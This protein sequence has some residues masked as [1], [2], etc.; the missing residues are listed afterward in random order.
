MH[1]PP[2][3]IPANSVLQCDL[4]IIGGGA[5]GI[6]IARQF[7]NSRHRVIL[8]ESGGFN[9]DAPTQELYR[10]SV[11]G[12][13]FADQPDYCISSRLRF[14]GG[15]TNHWDGWCREFDALDF[16]N[17]D[18][19]RHSGWP[20]SKSALQSYYRSAAE[21]VEIKPFPPSDSARSLPITPLFDGVNAAVTTSYYH[22][23]PPTRF[24]ARYRAELLASGAIQIITSANVT[25]IIADPAGRTVQSLSVKTL[26]GN[27]FSVSAR[28]YVL[29]TGGIENARLL[30]ASQARSP[31]GLGNENDLVGRYFSDHP[32]IRRAADVVLFG[33]AK[34]FDV[35]ERFKD[36]SLNQEVRAV[37]SIDE[38][39]RRR[40]HLLGF[41]AE[42]RSREEKKR[43]P[44][45]TER[46]VAET[47]A[48]FNRL[49]NPSETTTPVIAS[50]MARAEQE[51]DPE[52]RVT[53]TT[54]RDALGVFKPHVR[55][56]WNERDYRSI[57]RSLR[58]I[59][60][61]LIAVSRG[62]LRLNLPER[63]DE[64][65]VWGGKHHMGTTRMSDD[66]ARGVVNAQ[67]RMHTVQ[68]L[69]IAGSSVFPTF[70]VANPTYTIVAL[71][72]R[73]AEHLAGE[74]S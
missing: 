28:R 61:G 63:V 24:G 10:G 50:L 23:S 71:A 31:K 64:A 60:D 51:P 25:E 21:I 68:N 54:E 15:A 17:R 66:A 27:S 29:A 1:V 44:D 37:I 53:L 69:Y 20:F 13:L 36:L 14:F 73:L 18:W 56:R 72:L 22:Y 12:A 49:H 5:A 33:G 19:V 42:I 67:G 43:G 38:R 2:T 9:L 8:L 35:Y 45:Q 16:E 7:A 11:D 32:H 57:R 39:V 6:T 62:R 26:S 41:T 58:L 59:G 52:C 46:E 34:T 47:F 3:D 65:Q 4:C 48:A 74:L 30:L 40:E 55:W 70:S